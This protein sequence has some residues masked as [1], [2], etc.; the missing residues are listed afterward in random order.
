MSQRKELTINRERVELRNRISRLSVQP[1]SRRPSV[2]PSSIQRRQLRR[3]SRSSTPPVSKQPALSR[4]KN[5]EESIKIINQNIKDI[6]AGQERLENQLATMMEL[7]QN[8]D[9]SF[10]AKDKA[11]AKVIKVFKRLIIIYICMY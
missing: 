9:S 7:L 1:S 8:R 4:Q 6:L 5:V 3:P 10:S 2:E 11:F